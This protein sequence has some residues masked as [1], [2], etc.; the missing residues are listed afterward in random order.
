[1]SFFKCFIFLF[2]V[3]AYICSVKMHKN[4]FMYCLFDNKDL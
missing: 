2:L 3:R 4:A 1:M